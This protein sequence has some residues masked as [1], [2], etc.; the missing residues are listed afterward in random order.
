[1]TIHRSGRFC[2]MILALLTCQ[3]HASTV[4]QLSIEQLTERA[5]H[6]YLA[7]VIDTPQSAGLEGIPATRL[8]LSL[9][10]VMKSG[11]STE[12]PTGTIEVLLPG[13]TIDGI[14]QQI[15][16]MPHFAAGQEVVLFLS[17]PD[18]N[19]C[20]WPIGLAQAKFDVQ[21]QAGRPAQVSRSLAGLHRVGA[22]RAARRVGGIADAQSLE[23]PMPE[24]MAL[25][26]L[27]GR[28]QTHLGGSGLQRRD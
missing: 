24:A 7:T 20:R 8:H 15:A 6:I 25:E 1:M 3:A 2:L 28:I 22:G 16:G 14:R 27:L 23:D 18:P 12:S 21:R 19:G 10:Q 5:N 9:N 4:E 13:G 17:E 26:E 11:T